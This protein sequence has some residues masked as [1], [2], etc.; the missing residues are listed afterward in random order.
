MTAIISTGMSDFMLDEGSVKEA[1]DLGFINIYTTPVPVH[2]DDAPTGQLL[3]T[4]SL[5]SG[6]EGLTMGDAS[7]RVMSKNPSDIWSG[8]NVNSGTAAYFRWVEA[9]DTAV[10]ST[11]ERRIQGT[12][13]VIGADLILSSINLSNGAPQ[14]IDAANI[15]IPEFA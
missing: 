4:V 1:L 12:C 11:T 10:L 9:G 7:N 6:G 13:A 2:A 5:N 3:C 8:I 15:M 14:L